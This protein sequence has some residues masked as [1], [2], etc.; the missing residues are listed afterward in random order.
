MVGPDDLGIGAA[1]D[2]FTFDAEGNELDKYVTYNRDG[3]RVRGANYS[4]NWVSKHSIATLQIEEDFP[5]KMA[6]PENHE[7]DVI[8]GL[9]N[10]IGFDGHCCSLVITRVNT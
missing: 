4:M 5:L 7:V 8:N 2:G 1:V 3:P 10:S 9:I 6:R